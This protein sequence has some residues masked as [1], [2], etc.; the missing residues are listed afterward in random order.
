MEC[1]ERRYLSQLKQIRDGDSGR[2]YRDEKC[3]AKGE[4]LN[5]KTPR[6]FD[7]DFDQSA[8]GVEGES[9]ANRKGYTVQRVIHGRHTGESNSVTV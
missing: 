9:K 4:K 3:V 2:E 7:P 1:N 6:Q 5:A 8:Q